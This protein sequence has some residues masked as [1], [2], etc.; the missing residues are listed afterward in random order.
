VLEESTGNQYTRR[1]HKKLAKNTSNDEIEYLEIDSFIW[2][3]E[4]R[5]AIVGILLS[6]NRK[7]KN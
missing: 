7:R 4:V 3:T 2:Q 5:N 1:E 6:G